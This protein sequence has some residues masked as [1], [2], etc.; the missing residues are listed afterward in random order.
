MI[1]P[2]LAALYALSC[3]MTASR[4]A[5]YFR[6][7]TNE[8]YKK[9][10]QDLQILKSLGIEELSVTCDGKKS[11]IRAVRKVYEQVTLQRCT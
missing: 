10:K 2:I 5:L 11:I 7:S 6:Y 3:I 1:V 4:Y 9:L 8:F